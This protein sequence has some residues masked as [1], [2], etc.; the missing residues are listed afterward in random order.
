M[1]A[2]AWGLYANRINWGDPAGPAEA[3]G[4]Y[5]LG[6][7]QLDAAWEDE[8]PAEA[9]WRA[10][11]A[12]VQADA[13]R[14][15][16]ARAFYVSEVAHLLDKA[17]AADPARRVAFA[18]Q[19]N[20]AEG[21]KKGEIRVD[22]RTGLPLMVPDKLREKDGSETPVQSLAFYAAELQKKTEQ[23]VEL[24][25]KHQ[26]QIK[27]A[28][29]LSNQLN[30]VPPAKGLLQRLADERRKRADV[31]A[32]IK[33]VYPA[34][35]NTLVEDEFVAKRQ[36]ALERRLDELKRIGVASTRGP[37]DFRANRP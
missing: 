1:A 31:E 27:E 19:D 35:V 34:L 12:A 3:A 16:R 20:P 24:E 32:E 8:R 26:Q 23:R 7:A 30:G 22:A 6:K 36:L 4:E 28:I 10:G 15:A 11:R 33:V 25:D 37:G 5:T 9:A 29:A 18:D 17:S 21:L 14:L 13:S 2:W